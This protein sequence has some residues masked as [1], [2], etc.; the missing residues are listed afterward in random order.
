M[1]ASTSLSADFLR[2][3]MARG[4]SIVVLL[5]CCYRGAFIPGIKDNGS[6]PVEQPAGHGRVVITATDRM[7]WADE[8]DPRASPWR[9][10]PSPKRSSRVC[11]PERSRTTGAPPQR[12]ST[13]TSTS[14]SCARACRKSP[15]CGA[16]S[17]TPS[18][19]PATRGRSPRASSAS[20]SRRR[21]RHQERPQCR[22]WSERNMGSPASQQPVSVG[23][24]LVVRDGFRLHVLDPRT[25]SRAAMLQ[26][27]FR[28]M[29]AFLGGN[30]YSPA[31]G[32]GTLLEWDLESGRR[33]WNSGIRVRDGTI[34]VSSDTLYVFGMDDRV[35]AL[36]PA[37]RTGRWTR[38]LAG[39]EIV[40]APRA[41][42]GLVILLHQARSGAGAEHRSGVRLD[43]FRETDGTPVWTY[44]SADPLAAHWTVSGSTVYVVAAPD[45]STNRI[46]RPGPAE[47]RSVGMRNRHLPS[48][49]GGVR[50]FVVSVLSLPALLADGF[51][52]QGH[53]CLAEARQLHIEDSPVPAHHYGHKQ[54]D[55]V[56][57][58]HDV[59]RQVVGEQA[60]AGRV[61]RDGH[62]DIAKVD[63]PN[64][65]DSQPLFADA[66]FQ[67]SR[68]PGLRLPLRRCRRVAAAARGADRAGPAPAGNP[69][70]CP[71]RAVTTLRSKPTARRLRSKEACSCQEA[72]GSSRQS[73]P[74]SPPARSCYELTRT[75]KS[76]KPQ[77]LGSWLGLDRHAFGLL[78]GRDY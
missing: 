70:P 76:A 4:R 68:K 57:G 10:H 6:G 44:R 58:A 17:R 15:G 61:C 72:T 43:V 60:E 25:S 20:P 59:H 5:D 62:R 41:A 31:L 47:S 56:S 36:V 40:S 78:S 24:F 35:H 64:V 49:P 63:R 77:P 74:P 45:P 14:D 11:G 23:A 55:L 73:P 2:A 32:G 13:T 65:G 51:P 26:T 52:C 67:A 7:T 8:G 37:A 54:A 27:A 21:P 16:K 50:V 53:A 22:R 33:S 29:P 28:T 39:W 3:Q 71:A 38:P 48:A 9:S 46:G 19:W 42:D 1:L 18:L 12:G 34:G 69:E 75:E 30:S 66:P